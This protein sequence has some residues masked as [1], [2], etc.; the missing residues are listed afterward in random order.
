MVEPAKILVMT[1]TAP[2]LLT[3]LVLDVS[4]SMMLVLRELARM[5]QLVLTMARDTSVCV[6]MDMKARTVRS[7][8]TTASTVPARTVEPASTRSTT[9]SASVILHSTARHVRAR[10]TPALVIHVLMELSAHLTATIRSSSAPVLLDTTAPGVNWTLTSVPPLNL[11]RM[12]P[13][14]STPTE[15]TRVSVH[16]DTRDEIAS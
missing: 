12:E 14:V 4:M 8:L 3:S 5:E 10:L 1:S 15:A 2:A 9:S 6:L 7:T 11:A 16:V 13:R